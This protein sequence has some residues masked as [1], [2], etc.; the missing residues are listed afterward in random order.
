M[1]RQDIIDTAMRVSRERGYD[2][3]IIYDEYNDDYS[4]TQE[5]NIFLYDGQKMIYVTDGINL[6]KL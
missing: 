5:K 3:Y 6:V 4:F 1:N 2:M